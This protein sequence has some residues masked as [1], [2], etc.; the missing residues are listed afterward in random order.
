[1]KY[2]DEL[3]EGY[4]ALKKRSFKLHTNEEMLPMGE[5][6]PYETLIT[7]IQSKVDRLF[8]LQYLDIIDETIGT[9][10][11]ESLSVQCMGSTRVKFDNDSKEVKVEPLDPAELLTALEILKIFLDKVSKFS[12]DTF[13]LEDAS[14]IA[15]SVIQDRSGIWFKDNVIIPYGISFCWTGASSPTATFL[16]KVIEV[17]DN[18]LMSWGKDISSNIDPYILVIK[19]REV[20]NSE[21]NDLTFI[22]NVLPS[23]YT[24]IVFNTYKALPPNPEDHILY[25]NI[26]IYF[27]NIT[28]HITM[29]QQGIQVASQ[30]TQKYN[31]L[32][33]LSKNT[34]IP[35]FSNNILKLLTTTHIESLFLR[36]PDS[37]VINTDPKISREIDYTETYP[38][39]EIAQAAI[40]LHGIIDTDLVYQKNLNWKTSLQLDA[41]N[42]CIAS[43]DNKDLIEFFN[44]KNSY[45]QSII[46]ELGY[47][48]E[49][50]VAGF[51][52]L[53][54]DKLDLIDKAFSNIR[55][56]GVDRLYAKKETIAMLL[57]ILGE[58]SSYEELLNLDL[59]EH[60]DLEDEAS[61]NRIKKFLY[62]SIFNDLLAGKSIDKSNKILCTLV[63]I[64]A[65]NNQNCLVNV[66]YLKSGKSFIL[67]N[68]KVLFSILK[69]VG[70]GNVSVSKKGHYFIFSNS[71]GDKELI[72]DFKETTK[73]YL[74]YGAVKKYASKPELTV[75]DFLIAQK[76]M[77]TKL[78]ETKMA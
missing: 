20:F 51:F 27:S 68:N 5:P 70:T 59:L 23:Y 16:L 28:Q 54:V 76:D 58:K 40:K 74:T 71:K 2:F 53:Y 6:S 67:N 64:V 39:P 72:V 77:L 61:S 78:L 38:S 69:S 32:L 42:A 9:Q 29:Y 30:E 11:T 35:S 62:F 3:L 65:C 50:G 17:Y 24:K 36:K 13:T 73:V 57:S 41:G 48:T 55:T 60:I 10:F 26:N 18:L 21:V 1:M 52:K 22:N 33:G 7:S 15:K 46:N 25:N 63:G 66:H 12:N 47:S 4:Q 44:K 8:S 14:W 75:E 34:L 37:I 56:P 31:R 45:T 19:D 49:F 43:F